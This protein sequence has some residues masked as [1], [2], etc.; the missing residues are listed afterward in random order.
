[1]TKIDFT[2]ANEDQNL[3]P[4]KAHVGDAGYDLKS[5]EDV[6]IPAGGKNIV[7][8]HTGVRIALPQQSTDW[9]WCAYVLPR[10]GL[11]KNTHLQITNSPGLIDSGYR[12]EICVLM[13]NYGD[14]DYIIH[15]YDRIAQLVIAGVPTVVMENAVEGTLD[16]SDRGEAGFGST[17]K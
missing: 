1:M 3:V 9:C 16:E 14:T 6:T 17:G 11:S 7:M 8:V 12:G 2:V 5:A 13:R 4:V 10:S 15:K